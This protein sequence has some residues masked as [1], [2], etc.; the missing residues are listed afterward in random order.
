MKQFPESNHNTVKEGITF[1]LSLGS[2]ALKNQTNVHSNLKKYVDQI[3]T[4]TYHYY[5]IDEKNLSRLSI[6]KRN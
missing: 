2:R 3:D 1:T 5:T 4:R 6:Y